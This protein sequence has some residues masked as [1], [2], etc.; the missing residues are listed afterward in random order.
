MNRVSFIHLVRQNEVREQSRTCRTC[1]PVDEYGN[2]SISGEIFNP[3][4][5]PVIGHVVVHDTPSDTSVLFVPF[6]CRKLCPRT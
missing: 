1:A 5:I 4:C 3:T 2:G 6:F